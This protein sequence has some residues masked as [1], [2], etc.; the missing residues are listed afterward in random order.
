MNTIWS[1]DTTHWQSTLAW[2]TISV[3]TSTLPNPRRDFAAVV[4]A[5]GE[6]F[7]HG[8]GD[9]TSQKTYSDGWILNTTKNAMVWQEVQ[10]LQ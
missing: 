4:L 9:S 10:S 3:L 6:I 2:N 7:I 5:T 8:G 1:L